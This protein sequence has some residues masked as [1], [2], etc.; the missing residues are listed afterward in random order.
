MQLIVVA[1]VVH[2]LSSNELCFDHG[3]A[4]KQTIT[5]NLKNR[6]SA[7]F[8]LGIIDRFA[9]DTKLRRHRFSMSNDYARGHR[10]NRASKSTTSSS[11]AD[12]KRTTIKHLLKRDGHWRY[13][14]ILSGVGGWLNHVTQ[15]RSSK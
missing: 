3:S 10:M 9:Y 2:V 15:G 11:G 1:S 12:T 5:E 8:L 13:D 6:H 4:K 14:T 7:S